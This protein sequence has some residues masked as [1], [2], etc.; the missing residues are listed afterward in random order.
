LTRQITAALIS[1]LLIALSGNAYAVERILGFH[2]DITVTRD[3]GMTVRETIAVNAEGQRIKRGIYRDFPTT[4]KD[5]LGNQYKVGFD[6]ISVERNGRPE[7]FHT[8]RQN[9][10]VRIY[11]GSKNRFLPH[12]EHEY[13]LTY[14]TNRQLGFFD[15]HDELYWNV[16][17]N[18]WDFSIESA[19][20]SVTLPGTVPV[21]EIRTEG[22]TGP[23]GSKGQDYDT[24]V[25]N[26]RA[27]FITTRRLG[28]KEGLTIVTMWP[29]GH[30]TEPTVEDEIR[31]SF[32]DNRHLTIMLVGLGLV[33]IYYLF[34]WSRVGRDQ[35]EGVIVPLY[36]PPKGYSPA[37]MRFIRER[38]YDHKTFAAALV[39]LA[40]K[41][42]ISI[43]EDDGDFSIERN[44]DNDKKEIAPDVEKSPGETALLKKLLGSRKQIKLEK[45][46]H[47]LISGAIDAHKKSLKRDY[48]R[49][50]FIKNSGWIVP[51][52]MLSILVYVLGIFNSPIESAAPAM[53]MT[54][55]LSVWSVVVY[56]LVTSAV[57]AF[58]NMSGI[59]GSA[60]F[61]RALWFAG[62]FSFF[63]IMA[64]WMFSQFA[65]LSIIGMLL[66]LV[67]TNVVFYHL[68][69][70][71]TRAGRKLLDK[72]EGFREYLAVAEGDE[73]KF[74]G[75]PTKTTDLFEMY[76]PYALALN[77]EQQW[78]ERF[79]SV[80]AQLEREGNTYQPGWYHGRHWHH[81]HV[82]DFTNTL[83]SS[84]GS[85]ISSSS[86]APGS[87]SGG[88]GGGFSGG[89]GGGGGGGGW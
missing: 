1:L 37:S 29:K 9:N 53:F 10:G 89:G 55:W 58:R 86:T 31:Q 79:A 43:N 24:A 33:L 21:S 88:G 5:R 19:S 12:G 61:F 78:G 76:L 35:P 84:L 54:V 69:H 27:E 66:A 36:Y 67:G 18:G 56:F 68:L 74:K 49:I 14:R 17:G 70:A 40:V 2:S 65:S 41:G 20:A 42:L 75:A 45:A 25:E 57:K 38:G 51:G 22:Y 6:I 11:F 39:N 16:T 46:R 59:K 48:E 60:A 82:G 8:K 72:A 7:D 87:S 30:V 23:A 63:E 15:D 47:A 28:P 85:A 26:G 77:V 13:V 4:Y 52:A 64:I 73:L 50:Y 32:S 71:D 62:I 34:V 3:G 80:F 44:Y 81:H 83:G